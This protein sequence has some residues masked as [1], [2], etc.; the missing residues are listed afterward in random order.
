M[1]PALMPKVFCKI[2]AV[3]STNLSSLATFDFDTIK[4]DK[5]FCSIEGKKDRIILKF[6]VD[7]A[8]KLNIKVLC[9]GVEDE[10]LASYLKEI[11]CDY[12]QGYLY[13]KPLPM[14]EFVKKYLD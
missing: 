8:K 3:L 9:E 2:S 7:L 1:S 10:N 11:G 12:I 6:V 13:D 14:E 4:L 5:N